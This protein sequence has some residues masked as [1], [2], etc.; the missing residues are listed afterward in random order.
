MIA[1][2][3][4]IVINHKISEILSKNSGERGYSKMAPMDLREKT[5]TMVVIRAASHSRE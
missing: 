4:F 2:E 3:D 5:I 1:D